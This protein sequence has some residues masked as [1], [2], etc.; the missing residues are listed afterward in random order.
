M[1]GGI[2]VDHVDI[3]L[4]NRVVELGG[5]DDEEDG[6]EAERSEDGIPLC[7]LD[8]SF[9]GIDRGGHGKE[10]FVCIND[11]SNASTKV[12]HMGTVT[13][14]FVAGVLG[15][16]AVGRPRGQSRIPVGTGGGERRAAKGLNGTRDV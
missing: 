13:E 2:L 16:A 4:A 5:H 9:F 7:V 11:C 12:R 14:E 3:R 10:L 1:E 6:E 15:Y 8:E